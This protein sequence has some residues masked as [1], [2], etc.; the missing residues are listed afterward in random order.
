MSTPAHLEMQPLIDYI[1][2]RVKHVRTWPDGMLFCLLAW[3]ARRGWLVAINDETGAI[4]ALGAARPVA[5]D[6]DPAAEPWAADPAGPRVWI[7]LAAADSP[8]WLRL[9]WAQLLIRLGPREMVGYQRGPDRERA[10]WYPF[11]IF[12]QKLILN[13]H[14]SP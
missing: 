3:Y 5:A 7:Q 11:G 14:F 1:T 4:V 6:C 10:R 8:R 9:L 13:P 2:A 12:E